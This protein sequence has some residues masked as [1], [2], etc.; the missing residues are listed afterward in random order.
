MG[1]VYCTCVGSHASNCPNNKP[2]GFPPLSDDDD[3]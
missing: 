2:G 3:D 1:Y